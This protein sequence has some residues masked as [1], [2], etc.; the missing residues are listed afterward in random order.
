[1]LSPCCQSPIYEAFGEQ[2]CSVCYSVI[3]PVTIR[4]TAKPRDIMA[5]VFT[6]RDRTGKPM[7]PEP[8]QPPKGEHVFVRTGKHI[9][10]VDK[11][12]GK[13]DGWVWVDA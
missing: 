2:L 3:Q 8:A 12:R 9:R 11:I 5:W 7:P 4:I 10:K 6:A 13:P 1:M